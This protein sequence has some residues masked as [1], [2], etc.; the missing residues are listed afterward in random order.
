ASTKVPMCAGPRTRAPRS[1]ERQKP[2]RRSI[3]DFWRETGSYAAHEAYWGAGS[4][5]GTLL[6]GHRPD[7]V[8]GA[9]TGQLVVPPVGRP[10]PAAGR[11]L[12]APQVFAGP[13]AE[14]Q[15]R[16]SGFWAESF[17]LLAR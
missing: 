5:H 8:R 7:S 2:A 9:A 11:P 13:P 15:L 17:E 3:H 16:P 6:T 10:A 1:P 14:P 4:C 12:R